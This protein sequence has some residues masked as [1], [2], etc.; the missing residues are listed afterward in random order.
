VD[1]REITQDS[2]ASAIGVTRAALANW[3]QRERLPSVAAMV[4][5]FQR[6]G[7]SLDWIYGGTLTGVPYGLAALLEE[8]AQELGAPV[9]SATATAGVGDAQAGLASRGRVGG[10]GTRTLHEPLA[11]VP[12]PRR[13]SAAT[14]AD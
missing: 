7:V 5:L 12:V 6:F 3:E 13:G 9:G 14:R 8:A 11:D 1:G 10:R 2:L 4:R